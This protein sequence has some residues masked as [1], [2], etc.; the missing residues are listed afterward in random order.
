MPH[1]LSILERIAARVEFFTLKS[2]KSRKPIDNLLALTL[3]R[4]TAKVKLGAVTG[5]DDNRFINRINL[6]QFSERALHHLRRKG[7]LFTQSDSC[8]RV[9]NPD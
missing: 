3:I 8:S 4:F 2:M 6:A 1:D 5:R 9:I 7:N